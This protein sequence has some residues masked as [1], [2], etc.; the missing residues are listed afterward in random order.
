M[1]IKLSQVKIDLEHKAV[2]G[3]GGMGRDLELAKQSK[4]VIDL[5]LEKSRK[6]TDNFIGTEH[7]LLGLMR[8]EEGLGGRALLNLA[9]DLETV[10]KEVLSIQN[11]KKVEIQNVA[12]VKTENEYALQAIDL[13]LLQPA[14]S[15]K[16]SAV[17]IEPTSDK[18]TI[19][20]FIIDDWIEFYSAPIN[21]YKTLVE[22]SKLAAG[23]DV[24]SQEPQQGQVTVRYGEK[25][26]TFIMTTEPAEHGETITFSAIIEMMKTIV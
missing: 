16:A 24:S 7:L 21:A 20:H 14:I 1:E 9:I 10:R 11:G 13:A 2:R 5:A 17:K 23:L 18:V 8:E 19:S 25:D 4:R 15:K 12:S 6:L 22:C 26:R 3:S